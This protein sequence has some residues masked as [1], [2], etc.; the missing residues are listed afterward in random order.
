MLNG[1]RHGRG[2]YSWACGD[3]YTGEWRDDHMHGTGILVST[4]R[5]FKYDGGFEASK[6]HG[7]GTA[8]Y[9]NGDKYTGEWCEDMRAGSG[10]IVFDSGDQYE[11]EWSGDKKHG[12]GSYWSM[13]GYKF[14]GEW[15]DDQRTSD[16]LWT[17]IRESKAVSNSII[18]DA[19]DVVVSSVL[20]DSGLS[21]TFEEE[22]EAAVAAS[23]AEEV[24]SVLYA[25]RQTR[26]LKEVSTSVK[27]TQEKK[28]EI[29]RA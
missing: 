1:K 23:L 22:L 2:S 15:R 16:G 26:I 19:T 3:A 9:T 5:G 10:R 25:L 29:F 14:E 28:C 4:A 20:A 18:H 21:G 27:L 12:R 13:N 7:R 17:E 24:K 8:V 11:G 6:R